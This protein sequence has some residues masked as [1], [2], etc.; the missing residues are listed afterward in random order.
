[1][2]VKIRPRRYPDGRTV[3][4]ADIHVA[5]AGGI[6]TERFQPNAEARARVRRELSIADD[7]ILFMY[8]YPA[9]F[10][11]IALG[12]PNA[13]AEAKKLIRTV[14]RVSMD[15]GFAYAEAKIA[16]L[17]HAVV[18]IDEVDKL[19]AISGQARGAS[20]ERTPTP[21]RWSRSS[22]ASR[23]SRSGRSRASSRPP[24]PG[25]GTAEAASASRAGSPATGAASGADNATVPC[26][27][28]GER[29]G[30]R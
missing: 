30:R 7:E 22:R 15:D 6:D 10:D 3:W 24:G 25:V 26:A 18:F 19:K 11:A 14:A 21:T 1:M 20:G 8:A 17:E 13:V 27:A 29:R 16:E 4:T 5:P 2:R 28:S 12:G 9:C 23:R